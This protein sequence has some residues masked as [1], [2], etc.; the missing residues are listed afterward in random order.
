MSTQ[1]QNALGSL[2][3]ALESLDSATETQI[4]KISTMNNGQS[5]AIEQAREETAQQYKEEIS[6]L[7]IKLANMPA[8][9]KPVKATSNVEKLDQ[10]ALP[11]DPVQVADKLDSMINNVEKMLK[12][13]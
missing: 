8:Q 1:I 5:D 3:Q 11:F 7:K 12:E 13:A 6:Q 2:W 10:P 9:D 4:Q